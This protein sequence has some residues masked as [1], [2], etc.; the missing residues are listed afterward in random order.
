MSMQVHETEEYQAG[1]LTK[2]ARHVLS[3]LHNRYTKNIKCQYNEK[4]STLHYH[5]QNKTNVQY[6]NVNMSCDYRNFPHQ[7]FSAER[8]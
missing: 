3:L 4:L 5:I 6:K 8:Y 7:L 1:S 2:E